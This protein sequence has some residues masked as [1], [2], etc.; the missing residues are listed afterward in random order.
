MTNYSYRNGYRNIIKYSSRALNFLY[1]RYC[2]GILKLAQSQHSGNT[3]CQNNWCYSNRV[4]TLNV[5]P[6]IQFM[7]NNVRIK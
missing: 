2:A 5:Y 4:A 7:E 3:F 6:K 1:L